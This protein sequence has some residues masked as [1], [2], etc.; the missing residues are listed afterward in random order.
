[1]EILLDKIKESYK[2]CLKIQNELERKNESATEFARALNDKERILAERK[3]ALDINKKET[4]RILAAN[5][6]TQNAILV[7]KK[8]IEGKNIALGKLITEAKAKEESL[9]LIEKSLITREAEIKKI[10][11]VV[12][13]S[14]ET[15][16]VAREVSK[17]LVELDTQ[18]KSFAEA[19]DRV[20]AIQTSKATELAD[21]EDNVKKKEMQLTEGRGQLEQL[22]AT[23]V[24]KI[25]KK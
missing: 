6:E 14:E 4:D 20:L 16:D 18:R 12:S 8:E 1:M 10:E 3:E 17:Q 5:K 25:L 22:V 24:R 9:S 19:Q 13:L 23:A 11:D 21:K 2:F 7:Q 15:A